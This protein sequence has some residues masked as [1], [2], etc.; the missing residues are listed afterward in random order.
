MSRTNKTAILPRIVSSLSFPVTAAAVLSGRLKVSPSFTAAKVAT[1]NAWIW[2][3][4]SGAYEGCSDLSGVQFATQRCCANRRWYSPVRNVL[5]TV[6][7]V[8]TI[9]MFIKNTGRVQL[10]YIYLPATL[11]ILTAPVLNQE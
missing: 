3:E 9:L 8:S 6:P 1:K 4:D 5:Q 11:G 2:R 7:R 10:I